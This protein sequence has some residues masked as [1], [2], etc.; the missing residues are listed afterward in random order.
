MFGMSSLV[1]LSCSY[2]G[3]KSFPVV[4]LCPPLQTCGCVPG[5]ASVQSLWQHGGDEGALRALLCSGARKHPGQDQHPEWPAE[6]P[7]GQHQGQDADR[8]RRHQGPLWEEQRRPE[9]LHGG[10]TGGAAQLLPAV[11]RPVCLKSEMRWTLTFAPPV[12]VCLV[13]TKPHSSIIN[14]DI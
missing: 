13:T 10:Q 2:F 8:R 5:G 14:K 7:G 6:V 9:D 1:V 11:S 4:L 12:S 3:D